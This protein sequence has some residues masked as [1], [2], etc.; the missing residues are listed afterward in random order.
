MVDDPNKTAGASEKPGETGEK[1]GTGYFAKN[2]MPEVPPSK[3]LQWF[4]LGAF[5]ITGAAYLVGQWSERTSS[6]TQARFESK[7]HHLVQSQSD[8]L[9]HSKNADEALAGKHYDQAVSEYRLAL[10]SQDN[11]EGHDHLGQAL[12]KQGDADAAFI[13]FGNALRLNP[14][15]VDAASAWGLALASQGKPEEAAHVFQ[16]ALQSNPDSGLLHYDLGTA[17]LQ[18]RTSAEG[19]S[20]M[21][22][23]AGKTQEA[24]A[25]ATEAKGLADDA[26]RHFIKASRNKVDSPAFWCAYG[27]LLNQLGQY[28]EAE[29]QLLR[30][31]TEDAGMAA[32]QFQLAVADDHLGKYADAIAHYNKVLTLTPDNTDTL[33]SL[34]LL[35]ATATN[36]EV[37][38]SKMA[39]QLATR[40]CD[41]TG[42]QNARFMDTLARSYA[43]DGDYFQA[44]AWEDKAIHRATQLNEEDLV[45]EFQ[46]RQAKLTDHKSP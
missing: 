19:R 24:Q 36:A 14:A 34:A 43:A 38:T 21:A 26:L 45:R 31:I 42:N 6:K 30:S 5:L 39:V 3:P 2:P 46:A 12:L 32:A 23:G 41:A 33:N 15:L 9:A 8:Y 10:Q 40:A 13:E 35:Y 16:T 11:A 22:S 20:R 1:R 7:L 44:I 25:A 37:R 18:M 27:Q 29:P 4:L 28:A 17:L